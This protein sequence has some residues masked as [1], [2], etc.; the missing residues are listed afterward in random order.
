MPRL[1][2]FLLLSL[3]A[4]LVVG[5]GWLLW[6]APATT[7]ATPAG[8][9][10]RPAGASAGAPAAAVADAAP[11]VAPAPASLPRVELS[12]EDKAAVLAAIHEAAA[13]DMAALEARLATARREGWPAA[14][15]AEMEARLGRMRQTLA[16]LRARHPGA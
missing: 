16:D 1:K 13:T 5:V 12:A 7:V 11:A 14:D 9:S 3:S 2:I 6:P 4:F 15:I 10:T 8:S